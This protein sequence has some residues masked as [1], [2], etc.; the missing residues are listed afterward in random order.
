M[1]FSAKFG[2]TLALIFLLVS[3]LPAQVFKIDGGTSDLFNADG[4]TISMKAPNYDATFGAGTFG[5]QFALGAVA[6]TK[7]MGLH[8]HRRVTTMSASICP[9]TFSETRPTIPR[10][11]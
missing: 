2:W 10:A 1:F 9:R 8:G 5:G 7:V 11:A 4:G 6:R 3:R